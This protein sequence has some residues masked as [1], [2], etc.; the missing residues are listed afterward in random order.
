MAEP[1]PPWL[2]GSDIAG[3]YARGLQLGASIGQEQAR[4][5]VEQQHMQMEVQARQEVTQ[6]EMQLQQQK[7]AQDKALK[8]AQIG[9]RQQQLQELQK[10]NAFK[11]QQAAQKF[12]QQQQYNRLVQSGVDP[13]AAL[14][15]AG[16]GTPATA[17]AG[18]KEKDAAERFAETKRRHTELHEEAQARL[19][20]PGAG[21]EPPVPR[22]SNVP[23]NPDQPEG[24]KV[25]MRADSPM[26][27]QVMGTNAP[28]WAG[29]NYMARGMSAPA[30]SPKPGKGYKVGAVYKGGLRYMG[31][32]PQDENSWEKIN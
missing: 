11:T 2:H 29:T 24:A 20:K 16:M 22:F 3:E 27:N 14:Y 31:G 9:L 8:E 19:A 13:M 15:Q 25:S 23:L 1:I 28:A 6:R 12:A 17:I 26:V 32:D 21:V 10:V 5:Q 18:Q 4:L 7:L 30:P